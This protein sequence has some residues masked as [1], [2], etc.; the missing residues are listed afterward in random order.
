MSESAQRLL[1]ILGSLACAVVI[2]A[3]V[4]SAA[5]VIN[6][7]L[8]AMVVTVAVLPLPQRLIKR[9]APSWL[10]LVITIGIVVLALALVGFLL[11]ASATRL[12]TD[13]PAYVAARQAEDNLHLG[14][15]DLEAAVQ[16]IFSTA[17]A[18]RLTGFILSWIVG[19]S[20]T[21]FLMILI[22]VFMISAA[23]SMS[24]GEKQSFSLSLPFMSKATSITADVR[25]YLSVTTVLNFLVGL[26]DAIFLYILGVDYVL[27]WGLLAWF[28]GYIPAVGFWVALV[29]PTVFAYV[30]FGLEEAIIVFVG[31]VLI[32]GTVQNLLQPKMMGDRLK[33]TPVVVFISV[34]FW[35]ALLGTAGALVAVPL[36]LMGISFLESFE[37]THWAAVLL[38]G[39]APPAEEREAAISQAR[40]V[41]EKARHGTRRFFGGA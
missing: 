28:M 24:P 31:Y 25:R 12:A 2:F 7:I 10:A 18:S 41:W 13:I 33:I 5:Q 4:K 6:P 39:G 27:L 40:Q 8:L 34:L 15:E 11:F 1:F 38:R 29:P 9:G 35:A 3:G 14:L 36:T 26:G 37:A 22:F 32:N 19:F 30:Q 23:V 20:V 16:S 21:F 17:T